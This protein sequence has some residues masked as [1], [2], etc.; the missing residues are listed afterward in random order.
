MFMVDF[1]MVYN[2]LEG[3]AADSL[4]KNHIESVWMLRLHVFVGCCWVGVELI[5]E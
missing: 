2:Q 3:E 5:E 4:Q 1:L